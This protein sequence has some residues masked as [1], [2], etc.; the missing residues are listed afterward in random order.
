MRGSLENSQVV[1][2]DLKLSGF[3]LVLFLSL[4]GCG[5]NIQS[6][7]KET[8]L[9]ERQVAFNLKSAGF[10]DSMIPTMVCIAKHESNLKSNAVNVNV[11]GSTDHGIFQINDAWWLAECGVSEEMLKDPLVN[12]QCA[13][14]VFDRQGLMAW[15]G[16]QKN[17]ARCNSYQISE[18]DTPE[19]EEW[20]PGPIKPKIVSQKFKI[21][22]SASHISYKKICNEKRLRSCLLT[23]QGFACFNKFGCK[24]K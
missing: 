19:W 8:R 15:Y 11:N 14:T 17:W 18:S 10:P 1:K 7:R 23:G 9:T 3:R 2:A 21:S 4:A 13:K 20:Y 24:G 6:S 22:N 16:Y 5:V 12:A